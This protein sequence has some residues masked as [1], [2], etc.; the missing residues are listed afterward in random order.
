M[1]S[2]KYLSIFSPQMEAIVFAIIIGFLLI[3][4]LVNFNLLPG[5]SLLCLVIERIRQRKE[6]SLGMRFTPGRPHIGRSLPM[7]LLFTFLHAC[8]FTY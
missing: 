7:R 3:Y 6:S 2:D 5:L 4:F 1:A 8:T